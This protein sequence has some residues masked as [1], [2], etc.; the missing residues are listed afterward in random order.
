MRKK[1]TIIYIKY[2]WLKYVKNSI[3]DEIIMIG[4]CELNT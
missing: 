4:I 1:T 3:A 2:I